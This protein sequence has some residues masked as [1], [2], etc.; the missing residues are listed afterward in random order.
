MSW[1]KEVILETLASLDMM[2]RCDDYSE[3]ECPLVRRCLQTV[4]GNGLDN[5]TSERNNIGSGL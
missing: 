4:L 2:A 5:V 3:V 1:K